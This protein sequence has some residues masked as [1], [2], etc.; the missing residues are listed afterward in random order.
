MLASI[1]TIVRNDRHG[2]AKTRASVESQQFGDFEWLVIDGASTDGTAEDVLAISLSYAKVVSEPDR[3]IYDAMNKGLNLAKGE[4]VLFLNAG[5]IF[6][7][8]LTLALVAPFLSRENVSFVYGDSLEKYGGNMSVYKRARSRE[9]ISYGMFGCHQ[10]M[11]YRRK[12]IDEMRYDP[13]FH[14]AGD[15][16]FTARFLM[17]TNQVVKI[18]DA[19]CIFDLEGASNNNRKKGRYEN[20]IIQRDVLQMNLFKRSFNQL[21]YRLSAFVKERLPSFYKILRYRATKN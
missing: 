7:N 3:G 5:D 20:W 8:S 18:S 9:K 15:Y 6:P 13:R 4:F 2:L 10:A 16:D 19:L 12:V 14:I 21:V 11:Y 1:V 17:K